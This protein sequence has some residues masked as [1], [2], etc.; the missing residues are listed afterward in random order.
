LGPL[1]FPAGFSTN[2]FRGF[3]GEI[4]QEVDDPAA[5]L[6]N[7]RDDPEVLQLFET[8]LNATT[9]DPALV[10]KFFVRQGDLATF[11]RLDVNGLIDYAGGMG[12]FGQLAQDD[13]AEQRSP[14]HD[15]V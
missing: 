1:G 9:A 13:P 6:A 14:S 7:P 12:E 8:L 11:S 4:D 2:L 10:G 15:R 3:G 5:V